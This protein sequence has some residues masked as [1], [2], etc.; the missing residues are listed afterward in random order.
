MANK[1]IHG[2]LAIALLA[3]APALAFLLVNNPIPGID[4]I[5]RKEHGGHA[6][7]AAVTDARGGFIT[8][9]REPGN[10]QIWTE[11]RNPRAP[12]PCPARR[13]T[14]RGAEMRPGREGSYEFT[15]PR[16]RR[17]VL[18]GTVVTRDPAVA[19]TN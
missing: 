1:S 10:Y 3:P 14:V 8:Q 18:T 2:M 11:C 12:Q 5:V 6:L 4:I 7:T 13:L 16:G 9:V 19:P 17:V 15:V